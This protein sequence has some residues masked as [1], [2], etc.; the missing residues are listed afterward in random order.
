M[1]AS[2]TSKGHFPVPSDIITY[3]FSLPV[4]FMHLF[5]PNSDLMVFGLFRKI[6][7]KN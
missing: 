4:H 5:S 1:F 6:A 3:C 7:Q 2:L